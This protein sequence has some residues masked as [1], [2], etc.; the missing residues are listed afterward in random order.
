MNTQTIVCR[1]RILVVASVL[2]L[3]SAARPPTT[4]ASLT[5]QLGTAD[6]GSASQQ[7]RGLWAEHKQAPPPFNVA[8][9]AF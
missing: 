2:T 9:T 3:S 6:L 4:T 5:L 7:I 1:L 8:F